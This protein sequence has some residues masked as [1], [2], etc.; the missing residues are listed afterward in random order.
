M[1]VN[2]FTYNTNYGRLTIANGINRE[3]RH[4]VDVAVTTYTCL[5]DAWK[6]SDLH[7]SHTV[8]NLLFVSLI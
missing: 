3:Y 8:N 4:W 6:S 2:G 1:K 7:I 5:G